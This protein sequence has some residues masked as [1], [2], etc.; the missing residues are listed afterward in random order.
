[1][2]NNLPRVQGWA[3]GFCSIA[4]FPLLLLGAITDPQLLLRLYQNIIKLVA[5]TPK[6]MGAGPLANST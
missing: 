1:M 4:F 2:W 6:F 5:P 3:Y